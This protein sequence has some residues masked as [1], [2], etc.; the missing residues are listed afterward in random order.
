M[1]QTE[2]LSGLSG[3]RVN[4]P[5]PAFLSA[6]GFGLFLVAYLSLE[7]GGYDPIVRGE[8][9]LLVWIAAAFGVGS[10]A[11]RLPLRSP[12]ALALAGLMLGFVVWHALALGWTQSNERSAAELARVAGYLGLLLLGFSIAARGNSAAIL[13]GVTAAVA[14]I[15]GLGVLSRLEPSL[16]PP[17]VIG[18]FLPGIEIERRLSY[19]LNYSSAVGA[20]AGLSIPLIWAATA[21]PRSIA[22]HAFAA[23]ALPLAG[24]ALYLATSGTGLAAVLAATLVFI[25]LTPD[26]IARVAT[27]LLA[28]SGTAILI[29]G[30][31][32]RDALDRGLPTA[33]LEQQGDQLLV[34]ALV[35]CAGVALLQV[36][37][38][39]LARYAE[40]PALLTPNRRQVTIATAATLLIALPISI[41]AGL[42]G[43]AADRWETFKGR[44]TSEID[45]TDRNA[46]ILDASSSGRYQFWESAVS[47]GDSEPLH[48]IGPGTF[49]LWWTKDPAYFGFVRDGHSLYA[50]AFGELGWVGLLLIGGFVG[51][52]I[53]VGIA[54]SAAARDAESR[55]RIAAATAAM[56][57]FAVGAALDWLWEIAALPAIAML[58][59]VVISLDGRDPEP[60]PI[61]LPGG[62]PPGVRTKRI[63]IDRASRFAMVGL[64]V[65]AAFAIGLPL[66]SATDLRESQV[67]YNAGNTKIALELARS[68]ESEQPYGA[69]APAQQA[70]LLEVQGRFPEALEAAREAT[71]NEPADYRYWLLLSRIEARNSNIAAAVKAYREASQRNPRLKPQPPQ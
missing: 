41:A 70:M 10:G 57:G 51:G 58:L 55:L 37:I 15:C 28:A 39:L 25:A 49:E 53:G 34:I 4:L 68:A 59:A 44:G 3:K 60:D 48:G 1:E 38:S 64:S 24:F 32:D 18:T 6:F 21:W 26:R 20:F 31:A 43:A 11:L 50:E 30:L 61:R 12:V 52:S 2:L 17:N 36:A 63:R 16:F 42:P 13:G 33:A 66:A 69:E 56:A 27:L 67:A 22:V 62:E 45:Q 35:V 5:G 46:A 40:R 14:L 29:G 71:T 8:V 19:P 23:A 47:A 9:G 7:G 54:R 65:A